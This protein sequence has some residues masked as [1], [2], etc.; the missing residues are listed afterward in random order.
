MK[1]LY[2]PILALSLVV[3]SWGSVAESLPGI[4]VIETRVIEGRNATKYEHTS[5]SDWGYATA[6]TD[7]FWL[8][9]PT[10]AAVTNAPLQ[11]VLHSA[12]HSADKVFNDAFTTRRVQQYYADRET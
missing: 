4:T 5:H 3:L 9:A 7:Y 11:V 10:N 8:V 6:Q 2:V 1:K 12:G